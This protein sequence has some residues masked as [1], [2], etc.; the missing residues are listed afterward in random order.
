MDTSAGRPADSVRLLELDGELSLFD[1][2]TG[3]AMVLNRTAADILALADGGTT[4]GEVI[5]TLAHAYA[6]TAEHIGPS[7]RDVIAELVLS[8]VLVDTPD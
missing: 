8:G 7:V 6:V 1:T 2:R 5:D 3:P 4:V